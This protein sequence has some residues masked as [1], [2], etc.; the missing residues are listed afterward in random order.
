MDPFEEQ[1]AGFRSYAMLTR[2][3]INALIDAQV[4]ADLLGRNLFNRLRDASHASGHQTAMLSVEVIENPGVCPE[5]GS[6]ALHRLQR[7]GFWQ[8]RVLPLV[9][10]YPWRCVACRRPSLLRS[11]SGVADVRAR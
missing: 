10:F 7:R 3:Q 8:S 11:R 6:R 1:E 4:A 5:C 9:G 2:I